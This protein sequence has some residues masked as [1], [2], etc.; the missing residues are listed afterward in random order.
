MRRAFLR[1]FGHRSYD[2]TLASRRRRE[3]RQAARNDCACGVPEGARRAAKTLDGY[4]S[5]LFMG[6][7]LRTRTLGCDCT[8]VSN[9]TLE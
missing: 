2:K 5:L 6:A 7:T 9:D 8:L 3:D 4:R 1:A